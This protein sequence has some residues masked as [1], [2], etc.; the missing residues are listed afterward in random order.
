MIRHP[1]LKTRRCRRRLPPLRLLP[2]LGCAEDLRA[3]CAIQPARG[4]V[5]RIA[6]VLHAQSLDSALHACGELVGTPGQ[7]T[8]SEGDDQE[9]KKNRH[10]IRPVTRA[11]DVLELYQEGAS[12]GATIRVAAAPSRS[13]NGF[14]R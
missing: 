9:R 11:T 1:L 14:R 6:G 13:T 5:R 2:V 3:R 4:N 8:E 12:H 10:A 7:S